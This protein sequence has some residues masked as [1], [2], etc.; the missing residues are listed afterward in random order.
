MLLEFNQST[1]SIISKKMIQHNNLDCSRYSTTWLTLYS[2]LQ[3]M[4]RI[5]HGTC[6]TK[7]FFVT[8]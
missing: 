2:N 4:V 1:L 8:A 7:W 6:G 3:Y 5:G